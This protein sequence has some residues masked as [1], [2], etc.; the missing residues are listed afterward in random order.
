MAKRA[1]KKMKK[2][3]ANC[4]VASMLLGAVV[5]VA[6]FVNASAMENSKSM[7]RNVMYYGDWSIWGGQDNFYP[8]DIPADQLTHLNFAFLDFDSN[9]NLIFTDKGAAVESPVGEEGVQ[10]G[11]SNA[12]VLSALQELRAKNP[13]LKIG[14]SL[15]G[16]SKSGDF[17][18]VARDS[19]KRKNLVDNVLKFIKYTNMDFVDIDWEYPCS[20]REPDLVDNQRDEGTLNSI[21]E[22]KEN[23]I[24]LLKDLRNGIDKQGV[25]L[26]RPYELSVALPASKAQL[27]KGID[28]KSLFD[29]VDFANIMTY[30]M[31]GAWN[32]T[33]GHQTGLYTNPN[34]PNKGAGLSVDESVNY[35][36]SKGAEANKIVVG[37]AYYTRG[38]EK[39]VGGSDPKN[40]GLFGQAQVITKDSD[41]T[42]T[43]GAKNEAPLTMGDGGRSGGVWSYRSLNGLKSQYPGVKEYWDDSA[44][45]PYL[46]DPNSG[47]L[48]TYDNVKS[49]GEKAKYVN[50]NELGGMIGWMAGQDAPTNNGSKRDELTKATKQG[51]FGEN[52]LPEYEIKYSKLNV[53]ATV[54]TYKES[55]GNSGG[56]EITIKNNETP[57]ES[58][59]VLKSVETSAESLKLPKFYIKND[60]EQLSGDYTAGKV[61]N[62]DGYTVVDLKSVWEGKEI[63]QGQSYTFKLK[64]NKAPEN[65]DNIKNIELVQRL[66]EAGN[67]MARQTIFGDDKITPTN[68]A[69]VLSGVTDKTVELGDE[70]DALEGIT[71]TDKEDGILTNN[72]KVTGEV[73]T[74]AA[75]KYNLT[76]K[77]QDKQGLEATKERIITVKEKEESDLNFGV[78]QGIEWPK[79][80]NAPFTDMVS[81]ITNPDY[82]NNGCVNLTRISQDTGVKYFN[83]GFIQTLS[84]DIKDGKLQWGWGGYSVLN[85][86]N[87]TN[88]QYQGIKKSI[89]ELRENGGDVAISFGGANG[90]TLWEATQ[91]VEVLAN[92]YME[93]VKGYGLTNINL[94]I[95]GAAQDKTKNIA[96]AKAVKKV[97]DATGVK[98]VLTVPV[99]PSGLTYDQINLLDAYLSQGVDLEV[100]NLMTMCY[101]QGTLQPGENYGTASLRAVDSSKDQ[102]KDCYKRFASKDLTDEEAYGKLGTTPSIGYESTDHPVFTTEWAKLVVDHA[103]DRKIGM[104]SFWSMNRDAK[105][106]D[107][108]GIPSQYAFTNI[109]RS[110]GSGGGVTPPNEN[111]APVLN[112]V[113]NKTITVGDSFNALD[114]VSAIDREDGDLTKSIK[115]SGE[116]NNKVS[117]TY[118]LVY[119][120]TD[121]KGLTTTKE[122]TVTVKEIVIDELPEWSRE[123]AQSKGYLPGTKVRHKGKIWQQVSGSASWWAEP[124]SSGATEWKAIGDDPNYVE[125]IEEWSDSHQSSL[126]YTPGVKVT[127]KGNTYLQ[128]GGS[129]GNETV[130]WGEPGTSSGNSYWKLIK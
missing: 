99:L 96:N 55:W 28:I 13:N 122:R 121:S 70:F 21:P 112:G 114:G 125:T 51:L 44:K 95:E 94:D 45:A 75:G 2:S 3:V 50:D 104:T 27:D 71:A 105:L 116:V 62:E 123:Y 30:D 34:D 65:I 36:K 31:N 5:P 78:G 100:V 87:N 119:S 66:T 43:S 8:K 106:D 86:E 117:G 9:G 26:E 10:W 35:L 103:I 127:H 40:P 61:T 74:D 109:F 84:G 110:F 52:K 46:Y 11:A 79:Q 67:E 56:Y 29:I 129:S 73:N 12:G 22:D 58:N 115:V 76:Y 54:K 92:T 68:T 23:Y 97:Q 1:F 15:G 88:D 42:P 33:S 128:T 48:F 18:V 63:K 101:G 126:G 82:S 39:V 85:E 32:T 120:V 60:G 6:P 93:L 98:V 107:N 83:L 17:S 77:V 72:I 69:P 47:A 38:W 16:W 90:V 41:Q 25:E 53:T 81:W 108:S 91:D 113:S 49:V 4:V 37:A 124:G 80:V 102:L 14:V 64:A 24:K 130:W 89:R 111:S 19:A 57:N 20:V 7:K 118:K 59:D